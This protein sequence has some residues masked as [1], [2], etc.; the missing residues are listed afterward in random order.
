VHI[1]ELSTAVVKVDIN[2]V[3]ASLIQNQC[4]QCVLSALTHVENFRYCDC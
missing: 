2:V 1:V 3:N 4:L